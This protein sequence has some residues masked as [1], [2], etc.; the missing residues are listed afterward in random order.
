MTRNVHFR[1]SGPQHQ[2]RREPGRALVEVHTPLR[3]GMRSAGL[4]AMYLV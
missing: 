2:Y 1:L 3:C 4:L